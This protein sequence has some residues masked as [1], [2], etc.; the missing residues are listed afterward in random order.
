MYLINTKI[1][2]ILFYNAI[3]PNKQRE[4]RNNENLQN[5][6]LGQHTV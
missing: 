4:I 5:D 6:S 3:N 2:N 1:L